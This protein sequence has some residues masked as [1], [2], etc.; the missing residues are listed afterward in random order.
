MTDYI[1]KL[2]QNDVAQNKGPRDTSNSTWQEK[3]AHDAARAA[4]L[5]AQNKK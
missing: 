5:E 4:A 2:V 1:N 3:Q